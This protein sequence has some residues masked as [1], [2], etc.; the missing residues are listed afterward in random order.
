MSKQVFKEADEALYAAKVGGR[1]RVVIHA[2]LGTSAAAS[3]E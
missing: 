3:T 1:D 2:E